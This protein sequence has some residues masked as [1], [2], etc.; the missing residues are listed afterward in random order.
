MLTYKC[1]PLGEGV[2]L[3]RKQV[4]GKEFFCLDIVRYCEE[5][6]VPQPD[7]L[8]SRCPEHVS[9]AQNDTSDCKTIHLCMIWYIILHWRGKASKCYR[10]PAWPI[11]RP[12]PPSVLIWRGWMRRRRWTCS[13]CLSGSLRIIPNVAIQD[14][15]LDIH[16]HVRLYCT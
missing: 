5:Q 10:R 9:I 13:L 8:A 3:K 15:L 4:S 7:Q 12:C 2:D 14:P 6:I 1:T 11:S 16:C